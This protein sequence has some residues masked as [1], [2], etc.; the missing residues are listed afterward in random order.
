[1]EY[2]ENFNMVGEMV[3]DA[4]GVNMTYDEPRDFDGE[5]LPNEEA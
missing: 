1:M 3:E 5:E 2:E 4:F